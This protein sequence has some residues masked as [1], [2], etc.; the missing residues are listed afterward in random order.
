MTPS[1]NRPLNK[2]SIGTAAGLL[3][4]LVFWGLK[5]FAGVEIDLEGT[6]L[7]TS[8]VSVLVTGFVG[9]MTPLAPGEIIAADTP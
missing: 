1:S 4:A 5:K 6:A 9:Y 3:T 7:I 2:I 8:L